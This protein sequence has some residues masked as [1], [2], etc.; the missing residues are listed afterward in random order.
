MHVACLAGAAQA[1]SKM[2]HWCPTCK[3]QW[4]GS[5]RLE[6]A[7]ARWELAGAMQED[8]PDRWR[9]PWASRRHSGRAVSLTAAAA[10][11]PGALELQSGRR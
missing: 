2:W 1:M 8:E 10:A 5:L 3:Q 11:G 9:Q 6:L 7:R 4:T